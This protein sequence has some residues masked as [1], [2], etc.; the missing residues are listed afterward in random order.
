MKKYQIH[1]TRRASQDIATIYANIIIKL[2]NRP[3][4]VKCHNGIVRTIERLSTLGPTFMIS[5]YES[6][7]AACGPV[8]RTT[9]YKNYT[10]IYRVDVDTIDILRVMPSA[11]IK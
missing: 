2:R 7:Q 1:Y 11:L 8:A 10:I 5:P 6:V 3:A 4:A 9:T